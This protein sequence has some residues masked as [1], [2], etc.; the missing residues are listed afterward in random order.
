MSEPTLPPAPSGNPGAPGEPAVTVTEA[1]AVLL[2]AYLDGEL[3]GDEHRAIEARIAAEPPL[4]DELEALTAGRRMLIGAENESTSLLHPS[5]TFLAFGKSKLANAAPGEL[6]VAPALKPPRMRR[7]LLVL[8]AVVFALLVMRGAGRVLRMLAAP[9]RSAWQMTAVSG[10]WQ[11]ERDE[12]MVSFE[13]PA[14]LQV[15]DRLYLDH[16]QT[17]TLES[18]GGAVCTLEGYAKVRFQGSGGLFVEEG[19]LQIEAKDERA[20]ADLDK[21]VRTPDGAVN[22]RGAGRLRVQVTPAAARTGG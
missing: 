16:L 22:L 6:P 7:T 20:A 1:D 15:G 12:R 5:Q 2:S 10:T 18:P 21:A 4:R 19:L 9:E 17:A 3:S 13:N 11:V 14:A 8:G